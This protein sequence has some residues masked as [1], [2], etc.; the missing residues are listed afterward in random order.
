LHLARRRSVFDLVGGGEHEDPRPGAG[1]RSTHVVTV[2][3]R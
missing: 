3:D 2:N 1:E